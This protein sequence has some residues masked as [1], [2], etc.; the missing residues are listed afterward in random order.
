MYYGYDDTACYLILLL[1]LSYYLPFDI[2]F[3][4]ILLLLLKLLFEIN[5]QQIYILG[6][7]RFNQLHYNDNGYCSRENPNEIYVKRLTEMPA[8]TCAI[9]S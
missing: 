2:I 8:I 9:G 4:S 1:I 7:Q 5:T 3:H 6:V